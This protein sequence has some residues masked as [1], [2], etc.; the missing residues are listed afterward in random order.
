VRASRTYGER[1]ERKRETLSPS[2]V[3]LTAQLVGHLTRPLRKQLH[4]SKGP[5]PGEPSYSDAKVANR[6]VS[7]FGWEMAHEAVTPADFPGHDL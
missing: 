1:K 5:G 6:N 2:G 4:M 7:E 3:G